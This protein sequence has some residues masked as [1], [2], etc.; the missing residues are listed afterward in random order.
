MNPYTCD[1]FT[2][3][4]PVPVQDVFFYFVLLRVPALKNHMAKLRDIANKNVHNG[5]Q[6]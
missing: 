4:K 5:Q 1:R 6:K 3:Y 2:N